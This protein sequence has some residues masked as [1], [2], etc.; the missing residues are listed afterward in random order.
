MARKRRGR[1]QNAAADQP[2]QPPRPA[3]PAPPTNAPTK[4]ATPSGSSG[5]PRATRKP[6]PLAPE[7]TTASRAAPPSP[8]PVDEPARPRA[9][10]PKAK[11]SAT[12]S[13]PPSLPKCAIRDALQALET[14]CIPEAYET[15]SRALS[16]S[17]DAE[18]QQDDDQQVVHKLH[19]IALLVCRARSTMELGDGDA[20]VVLKD[21]DKAQALW[22]KFGAESHPPKKIE[23]PV[24]IHQV[25]LW[26]LA[27]LGE[28]EKVLEEAEI[29]T[30]K[31]DG[32]TPATSGARMTAFFHLGRLAEAAQA[33]R[34][35]LSFPDPL[36]SQKLAADIL[37]AAEEK[38]KGDDAYKK[39][40]Q[41]D[42]AITAYTK[43]VDIL[44]DE[45]DS[46]QLIASLYYNLGM[47]HLK[48][49]HVRNALEHFTDAL[50]FDASHV[51][52]LRNRAV[53]Y[54]R[55]G[56]LD[57]AESD[58]R[59]ALDLVDAEKDPKLHEYLKKEHERV[60]DMA[61]E[62][63][64]KAQEAFAKLM[65][66]PRK[67]QHYRTLGL[68]VGATEVE[69]KTAFKT[70]ARQHHPDKG[71]N[72]EKFKEVRSAYEALLGTGP[73]DMDVPDC[74]VS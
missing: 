3:P 25:R 7:P 20:Q 9:E 1:A 53:A 2:Q 62:R 33:A 38:K 16:D 4:S 49:S 69:I 56:Y 29:I 57:D 31:A 12:H 72:P 68:K 48:L 71:G 19:E 58:L 61:D 34:I 64:R 37:Q 17:D 54:E 36:A 32:I 67:D 70:L 28:Y 5:P 10:P 40:G 42:R 59:D 6:A 39:G 63:A 41:W 23:A 24:Q 13:E 35:Y 26:A 73:G 60:E 15:L 8:K 52:A 74:T 45:C 22:T 46:R 47:A 18:P 14:G 55:L 44:V 43:A 66:G 11:S 30:E 51:K 65:R 50:D 21:L 27:T